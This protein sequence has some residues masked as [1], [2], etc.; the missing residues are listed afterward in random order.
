VSGGEG[1]ATIGDSFYGTKKRTSSAEGVGRT[2]VQ[3]R[4]VN[5]GKN[6]G[7]K[8]S[9]R[10]SEETVA[11]QRGERKTLRKHQEGGVSKSKLWKKVKEW[12]P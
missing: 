12:F 2:N 6:L 10:E 8:G 4:K 11:M 1:V 3:A 5:P 7:R 9:P